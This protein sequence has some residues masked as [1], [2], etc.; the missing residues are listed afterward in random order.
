M[1]TDA[2][3]IITEAKR[4]QRLL[5]QRRHAMKRVRDLNKEIAVVRKHLKALAIRRDPMDQLP[6]FP[7]ES[8]K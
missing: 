2:G 6:P 8:E 5:T 7:W 1:P 4:L 3:Q